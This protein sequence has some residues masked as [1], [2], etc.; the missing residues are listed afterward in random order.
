M[1]VQ[2]TLGGPVPPFDTDPVVPG[3]GERAVREAVLLRD[4][5]MC[6]YCGRHTSIDLPHS[7][8]ARATFDHVVPNADGGLMNPDNVVVAC[9]PCNSRKGRRTPDEAGMPLLPCPTPGWLSPVG[10]WQEGWAPNTRRCE[11]ADGTPKRRM[12]ADEAEEARLRLEE[13]SRTGAGFERFR[14]RSCG[15]W[16]VRLVPGLAR[17]RRRKAEQ[18]DHFL[19]EELGERVFGNLKGENTGPADRRLAVIGQRSAAAVRRRKSVA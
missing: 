14:C 2:Q 4:L 11:K 15:W 6:R 1:S 9:S 10:R 18:L 3:S 16:H 19:S 12:T 8:P 5:F 13:Q 17:L 7:H